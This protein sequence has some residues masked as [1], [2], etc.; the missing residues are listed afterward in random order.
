MDINLIPEVPK[1]KKYLFPIAILL[2]IIVIIIGVLI[3][4]KYYEKSEEIKVKQ[5]ELENIVVQEGMFSEELKSK[6]EN[7]DLIIEYLDVAN[8][9]ISDSIN[10]LPILDELSIRLPSDATI[11]DM[12][13]YDENEINIEG[14]FS[15]LASVGEYIQ[16]LNQV[17]WIEEANFINSEADILENQDIEYHVTLS[18]TVNSFF[19]DEM[20]GE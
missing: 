12:S 18:I 10:W 13:F 7:S 11:F 20:G 1:V 15:S 6:S 8:N 3:G 5:S 16:L 2:I 17:E 9:L 14:T 19:F 4:L